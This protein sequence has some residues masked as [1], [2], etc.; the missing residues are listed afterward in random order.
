MRDLGEILAAMAAQKDSVANRY[1]L[2]LDMSDL[3]VKSVGQVFSCK[4]EEVAILLVTADGKHLRFVAPR[5][6]AELGTI[7]LTK[8]DAIAVRVLAARSGEVINNV[9]LVRHVTFF[10]SVK[11]KDK[12]EPIQK[13][14]TT[15]IVA[16]GQPIGVVEISR[17]GTNPGVA[18]PDFSDADLQRAQQIFDAIGPYLAEARPPDF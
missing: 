6:F 13:M 4:P 15:P 10:E 16:K 5:P 11:L 17:K 18:G 7:P 14:V 12:P 2:L 9:P 1:E 3:I 8:R